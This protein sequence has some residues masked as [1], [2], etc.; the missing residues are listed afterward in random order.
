MRSRGYTNMTYG[1][2]VSKHVIDHAPT[3]CC[4][5]HRSLDDMPFDTDFFDGIW[6]C[7]V[8]EHIPPEKVDKVL[9]ELRRVLQPDGKIAFSISGLP[10][11]WKGPKGQELHLTIRDLDWWV[12]VLASHGL[13]IGFQYIIPRRQAYIIW[14]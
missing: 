11:R 2:D 6:C 7:D 4:A 14:G 12:S 3:S 1:V 8:M 10:A 9:A 13:P 5:I